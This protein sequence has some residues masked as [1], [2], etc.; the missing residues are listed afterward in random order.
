M[1]G[2]LWCVAA[3]LVCSPVW[4]AV[5]VEDVE[6]EHN[7]V[8]LKGYL[9]YDDSV[10]TPRPGVLVVHE[11]W[12]LGPH[13]KKSAEKLADMG[14]VGF[15][16]DMYG[17]GKLTDDFEQAGQW[18]GAFRQGPDRALMRERAAAGLAVLADHPLC[19]SSRLAAIGY[20]F[21]GQ[22]VLELARSGADVD[23]VASFH[24]GLS[25]PDPSDAAQI[26]GR[27][28]VLHGADDPYVSQEEIDGFMK[29]MR[30]AKV[31]WQMVYYGNAVHSFT[32]PEAD[33]DGAKYHEPSARRSWSALAQFL[34]EIFY[35]DA[36]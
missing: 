2:M 13:A 16:L 1:R 33:M 23:G 31:D 32:N 12:G 26:K 11:W 6:Y 14:Y 24:G 27:V 18:A 8:Q 17:G 29:E 4:A 3:V 10:D 30:D 19:D 21:G 28:L 7:G 34:Q 5:Q 9:A 20:C 35:P 15:A 36:G 22:V 25:T